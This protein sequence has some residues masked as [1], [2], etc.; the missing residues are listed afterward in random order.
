LGTFFLR[1]SFDEFLLIATTFTRSLLKPPP[2]RLFF[3]FRNVRQK[4]ENRIVQL[5]QQYDD[6][7]RLS[8]YWYQVMTKTL[9]L[10]RSRVGRCFPL[11]YPFLEV[12][13]H[14]VGLIANIL[15]G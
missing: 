7:Y 8:I 1:I 6:Y 15:T 5:I 4:N 11:P 3:H 13:K 10:H 2:L 14:K 12:E 9:V